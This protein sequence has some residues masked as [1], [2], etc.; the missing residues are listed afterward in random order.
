MGRTGIQPIAEK[1]WTPSKDRHPA[2]N[3]GWNDI[4]HAQWKALSVS[5]G[6]LHDENIKP[7]HTRFATGNLGLVARGKTDHLSMDFGVVI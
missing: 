3:M 1:A 2:D 4:F 6:G 5:V 7:T